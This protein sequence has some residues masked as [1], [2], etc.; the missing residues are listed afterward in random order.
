MLDFLTELIDS[1]MRGTDGPL[2]RNDY[3]CAVKDDE[4][5]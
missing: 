2:N 5:R 1:V 3:N 4:R